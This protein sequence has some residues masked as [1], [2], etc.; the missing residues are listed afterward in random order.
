[1]PADDR[2]TLDLN[3][4]TE[5]QVGDVL[6]MLGHGELS[7]LIAWCGD[8]IYSH[9]AIVADNAELIEAAAP[10]ARRYTLAKRLADTAEYYFIDAFRPLAQDGRAFTDADRAAV[11]AHAHSLLGVPFPVDRL[12]TLGVLVAVRGK[13]PQHWLARLL[14]REAL[15][16]LVRN[17]PSHMVCSELVYRSLAECAVQP[18]GRLAPRIVLAATTH[19]PF[20]VVDWKALWDEVWPLLHPARHTALAGVAAQVPALN[21]TQMPEIATHPDLH[22]DDDELQR[23][24]AAARTMLGIDPTLPVTASDNGARLQEAVAAAPG[25][26]LP[27]PNPKLVTPLDLAVTPSHSVLGRLMQAPVQP[28]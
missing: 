17:D 25:T 28:Q 22:V 9:A 26:D 21:A 18:R 15:D 16:H 7:K 19:E 27:N 6:L 4:A 12:A 24:L 5:L 14:V 8:S 11:L 1:M 3:V 10:S 2:K 23:S 20:P 13:W